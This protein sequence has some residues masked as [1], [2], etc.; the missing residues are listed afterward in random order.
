MS[1]ILGIDPG[2]RICGYGL[3]KVRGNSLEYISS[4]V[5]KMGKCSFP[6]RLHTIFTDISEIIAEYEPDAAAIEEVFMGKN[7]SSA[8]KLG[9]ARGAAIVACTRF[10]I[11]VSEY[12]ARTV[13]LA[14]VGKGQAEKSQV[15]HM[16]KSLFGLSR[17]PAEDAADALA[18]AV[19]HANT[20]KTLIRMAGT[21]PGR[22]GRLMVKE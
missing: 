14:M 5:I 4:G 22:R 2:S 1:V 11:P 7:A 19:C 3:I 10:E 21:K 13:K 15:Q 12:A 9:Q 8:L 16:V 18:I 20:E 6:E 17:V